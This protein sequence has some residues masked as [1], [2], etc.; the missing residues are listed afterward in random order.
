[1]EV[2]L[3]LAKPAP[4][5]QYIQASAGEFGMSLPIDHVGTVLI[6]TRLD[7]RTL[8]AEHG[9]PFRLVVPDGDCFMHTKWLD[10][11]ELRETPGGEHGGADYFGKAGGKPEHKIRVRRYSGIERVLEDGICR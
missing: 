4:E 3:S 5:A 6:A 8:S 2:S 7:G 11:L 1:M 10:H 9:G